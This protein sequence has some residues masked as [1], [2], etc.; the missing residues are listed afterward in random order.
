M[1]PNT[2]IA[3]AAR[4]L[5]DN[6]LGDFEGAATIRAPATFWAALGDALREA[7]RYADI[8]QGIRDALKEDRDIPID[9]NGKSIDPVDHAYLH[10]KLRKEM[11]DMATRAAA[12][13]EGMRAE[14]ARLAV[15]ADAYDRIAQM[16]DMLPKPS[17][18]YSEDV[19]WMLRKR[20][21]ELKGEISG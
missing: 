4:E 3:E 18:G 14:N 5:Y 2:K 8:P 17:R 11:I 10:A 7:R 13:I 9:S 12:E 16:L 19:A 21:A 20:V 15:K 1:N 6:R